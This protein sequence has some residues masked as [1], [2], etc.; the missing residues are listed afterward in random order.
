MNA[1]PST[2][3]YYPDNRP[4]ITRKRAGRGFSYI[5]P[6]GTR[7][8]DQTERKRLAALAVPPAY[9]KVW[10]C[11]K[12]NGHLQATGWDERERKQYRYHPDWTAFRSETK[13]QGLADFG[14]ALPRIRARY[15]RALNGEAGEQ[16]F[17]VAAVVAMI[18]RLS[19]RIGHPEYA[20]ENGT[21]GATTLKTRH[22][23]L[24]DDDLRLTYQA[25]GAKKVTRHVKCKTLLRTLQRLHDLPGAELVKWVDDD[26]DAR[27]VTSGQVNAWLAEAAGDGM[28]AKTFRTWNGSVAALEAARLAETITIKTM[29]E[30]A[31]ERLANTPTIARNS[32]IH[33]AVIDLSENPDALPASPSEVRGLRADE[34]RLLD[35]LD[36]WA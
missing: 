20:E 36:R 21:Y 26:G 14:R 24:K 27:S 8:D 13:F 12:K 30:A 34:R 3:V 28:T 2:L 25:K 15:L 11:P 23:R 22:M 19:I 17:A 5:A 7:I 10:I 29:S 9:R 35:L 18:D 33:P 1:L 31:A 32:Y 4:G 6:D 16:A